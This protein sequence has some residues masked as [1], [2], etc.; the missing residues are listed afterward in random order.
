MILNDR[1]IALLCKSDDEPMI[2][3]FQSE[4]TRLTE[5]GS[6]VISFGLSSF[7][8]DMTLGTEFKAT[9]NIKN[10]SVIDPK[11]PESTLWYSWET[12]ERLTI[13]PG[14][15]ILGLSKEYW[16]MP[17]D[18]VGV[19]IGK[20]TYAR[21]GIIINC[22]PME[23]GW[24]GHL[25]IEIVNGSRQSVYLYP[26]EGIAQVLFFRGKAPEVNY[27]TRSGKYNGQKSIRVGEA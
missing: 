11:V 3:P 10:G 16:N 12:S 17:E 1:Q 6:K 13:N 24:N 7:G 19:V 25:V 21:S 26:N 14:Q 23:P 5:D 22:T 27:G 20:S 15:M 8:Y 18:V 2:K 9:K 4:Q